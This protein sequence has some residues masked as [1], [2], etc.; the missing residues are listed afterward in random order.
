[1]DNAGD[2][3]WLLGAV[4]VLAIVELIRTPRPPKDSAER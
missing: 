4:L 2:V 3:I 1:M